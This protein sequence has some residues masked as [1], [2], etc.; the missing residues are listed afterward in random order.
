[1]LA[2]R[3][4]GAREGSPAHELSLIS[5]KDFFDSCSYRKDAAGSWKPTR[6]SAGK[7]SEL[8]GPQITVVCANAQYLVQGCIIASPTCSK[9]M[10]PNVIAGMDTQ[11]I[12]GM[13]ITKIRPAF[14]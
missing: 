13:N 14:K 2:L 5:K 3:S 8:S 12:A 4:S 7:L 9:R 11:A 6:R 10:Q 1:M